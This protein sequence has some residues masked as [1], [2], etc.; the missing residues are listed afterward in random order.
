MGLVPFGTIEW[1]DE[2]DP[3]GNLAHCLR[4]GVNEEIVSAV[5]GGQP[6]SIQMTLHTADIAM[7][8]PDRK[9]QCWTIL[10]DTYADGGYR[11]ITGWE[12]EPEE[13]AEWI[14]ATRR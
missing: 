4:H 9:G 10:F 11:P 1:D 14:R 7:V 13:I 12:S 8:G 2:D 6:V 3:E 5:L